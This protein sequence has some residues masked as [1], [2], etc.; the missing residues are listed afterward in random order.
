MQ[1]TSAAMDAYF[2]RVIEQDFNPS[3]Q[4]LRNAVFEAT[5]AQGS[6]LQSGSRS[7]G[8]TGE[9]AE[10]VAR[11]S[12]LWPDPSAPDPERCAAQSG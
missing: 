8:G 6:A 3:Y 12:L 9:R 11:H 7:S 5:E 4:R 1:I 2:A 10:Q